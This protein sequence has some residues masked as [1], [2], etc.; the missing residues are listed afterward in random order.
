MDFIEPPVAAPPVPTTAGAT[1]AAL[2][3]RA[4]RGEAEAMRR[5][6]DRWKRP[7]HVF[8]QRALGSPADAED[9][10]VEVFVRLQRAAPGYTPT[11]RFPTFLFHIARNLLSNE[12]RRRRREPA[13]PTD[14][15]A[16]DRWGAETTRSS[17]R[18]GEVEEIF[19][20]ALR[21]LPER[22]RA[23]LALLQQGLT[24]SSTAKALQLTPNAL[25][26]RVHRAR[27]LL[28]REMKA[29]S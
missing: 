27:R 23:P 19:R 13:V 5:L 28:R 14:P 6:F 25:R 10:M 4:G 15:A 8:F 18:A 2:L 3:L 21:R 9:L 16:F 17:P 29:L 7:L 1:D 12:Q 26:V 24:E 22:Y 20:E 11:A